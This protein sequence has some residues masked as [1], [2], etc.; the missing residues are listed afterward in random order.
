MRV[1]HVDTLIDLKVNTQC[2]L[3]SKQG[4]QGYQI[5]DC[6]GGVSNTLQ[7]ID[8]SF[9]FSIKGEKHYWRYLHRTSLDFFDSCFLN[10]TWWDDGVRMKI[11]ITFHS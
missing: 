9:Q 6:T 3:F 10:L 5:V 11:N 2:M 1:T 8:E 4:V 7:V